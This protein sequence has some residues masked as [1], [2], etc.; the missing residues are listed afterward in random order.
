MRQVLLLFSGPVP[1]QQY[2]LFCMDS[3]QFLHIPDN[4]VQEL[5]R[6][7]KKKQYPNKSNPLSCFAY[8]NDKLEFF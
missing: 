1:E 4:Y 7:L 5:Y 2:I 3:R 8:I 6:T